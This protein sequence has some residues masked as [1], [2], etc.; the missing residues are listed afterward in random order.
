MYLKSFHKSLIGRRK[1][2]RIQKWKT[3]GLYTNIQAKSFQRIFN[4]NAEY[5]Q[6]DLYTLLTSTLWKPDAGCTTIINLVT[7]HTAVERITSF[8]KYLERLWTQLNSR[9]ADVW[10]TSPP[11]IFKQQQRETSRDASSDSA[12]VY[13]EASRAAAFHLCLLR[14]EGLCVY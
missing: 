11:Y 3:P 1:R 5:P 8:S 14:K 6:M 10:H 13:Y 2:S 4:Q 12:S 9:A 7:S